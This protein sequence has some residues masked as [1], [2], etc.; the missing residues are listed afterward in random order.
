[1]HPIPDVMIISERKRT[2]CL[3]GDDILEVFFSVKALC[4]VLSGVCIE[5]CFAA[6]QYSNPKRRNLRG[7]LLQDMIKTHDWDD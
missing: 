4:A 2:A 1:M 5:V 7:K 3:P 6:Q